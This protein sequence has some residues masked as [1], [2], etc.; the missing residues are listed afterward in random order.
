MN[1]IYRK[2]GA[3]L[4]ITELVEAQRQ[5]N[6]SEEMLRSMTQQS[7]VAIGLFETEALIIKSANPAM[8]SIVGKNEMVIGMELEKVLPELT[9]Q[10][11][12]RVF[13]QVLKSGQP[14]DSND[15]PVFLRG[16]TGLENR[17]FNVICTPIHGADNEI[18]GIMVMSSDF[19]WKHHAQIEIK[20]GESKF[21]NLIEQSPVGCSLMVGRELIIEFT[22]EAMIKIWGKGHSVVGK[23]LIEALPELMG[24]PYI[25][26]L[27]NVYDSGQPYH[28]QSA[29][30]DLKMSGIMSTFISILPIHHFLMLKKKFTEFCKWLLR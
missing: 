9:E 2:L 14:Y 12:I 3:I 23:K 26:I 1:R 17:Y 20:A 18:T 11:I 29:R 8:L 28:S 6:M 7:P 25:Q 22:N 10:D 15:I 4:D 27:E 24:Q 30:A 5:L 16:N 13:K 19:T 21:R